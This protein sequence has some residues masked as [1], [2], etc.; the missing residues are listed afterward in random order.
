MICF[1]CLLFMVF[2]RCPFSNSVR[3][4][5]DIFVGTIIVL[6]GKKSTLGNFVFI[7]AALAFE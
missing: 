2:G 7:S 6:A 5:C 1:E 4:Q 3:K